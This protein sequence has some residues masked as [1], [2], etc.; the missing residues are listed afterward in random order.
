MAEMLNNSGQPDEHRTC[1]SCGSDFR[2]KPRSPLLVCGPCEMLLDGRG[3][4]L[5]A[6]DPWYKPSRYMAGLVKRK[7]N[8]R[9][10]PNP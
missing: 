2:V 7:L 9:R 10:H 4:G 3:E 6:T 1:L 5:K 8:A